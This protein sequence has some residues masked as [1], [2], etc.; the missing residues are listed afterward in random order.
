MGIMNFLENNSIE[1][2]HQHQ[3]VDCKNPKTN[4]Y[5]KFDFF[6]PSKNTL[7]EFDGEQHF[8][9]GRLGKHHQMTIEDLDEIQY[10]DS[11][12]SKYAQDKGI[13]LVRISYKEVGRIPQILETSLE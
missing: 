8:K 2:F 5:L 6:I 12:K 10:R 4:Y 3:F 7:V 9:I 11:L 1:Y 13:K